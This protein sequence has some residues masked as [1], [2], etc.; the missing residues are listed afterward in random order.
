MVYCD[1]FVCLI[2]V[3]GVF[4]GGVLLRG[5]WWLTIGFWLVLCFCGV[6]Q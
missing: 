2:V 4:A 1:L 6:L 3:L 5:C